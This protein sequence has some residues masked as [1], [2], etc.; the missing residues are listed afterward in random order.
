MLGGLGPME[1]GHL[2]DHLPRCWRPHLEGDRRTL[3]LA[4]TNFQLKRGIVRR[5]SVET[6]LKVSGQHY[7]KLLRESL[8]LQA[9]L[10]ELTHQVLAAQEEERRHISHE[11]Q[12]EIAQT[13][14]GINVRLITLKKE[15]RTNTRGI[16]QEI[17]STQR[18]VSKSA[19]SVRRVAR[20][21]QKI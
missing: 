4:A 21:F 16:K 5:Q 19:R 2:A 15:S 12:D 11:L 8:Q 7:A 18:L 9:N 17:A 20:E 6:A 14:L 10:R 1:A 13:L 3:E